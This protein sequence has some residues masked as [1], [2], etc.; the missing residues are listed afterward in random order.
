MMKKNYCKPDIDKI[1]ID[2]DISLV[3]VSY[4]PDDPDTSIN[5]QAGLKFPFQ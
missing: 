2:K 5:D 3:M 4:P 1:K